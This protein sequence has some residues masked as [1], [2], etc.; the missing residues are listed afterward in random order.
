MY[1]PVNNRHDYESN[2]S[3]SFQVKPYYLTTVIF[4][5]MIITNFSRWEKD[6]VKLPHLEDGCCITLQGGHGVEDEESSITAGSLE[7]VPL[8]RSSS[9]RIQVQV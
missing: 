8:P 6:G 7:L 1:E 5:P 3:F 9:E 4:L 2:L